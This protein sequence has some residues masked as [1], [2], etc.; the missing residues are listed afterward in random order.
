MNI[1]ERA[2]SG[3]TSKIFAQSG[4]WKPTGFGPGPGG[5]GMFPGG[6]GGFG[7]RG[8]GGFRGGRR[9][10][11]QFPVPPLPPGVNLP[12]IEP[13]AIKVK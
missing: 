1:I 11:S 7:G 4:L 2:N 13:S 8:R 9:S 12:P 3:L 10:V 5:L 6:R